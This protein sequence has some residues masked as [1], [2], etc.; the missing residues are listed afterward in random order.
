MEEKREEERRG[1]ERIGEEAGE[2]LTGEKGLQKEDILVSIGTIASLL[3]RS[4][5][6]SSKHEGRVAFENTRAARGLVWDSPGWA[7]IKLGKSLE[8]NGLAGMFR[9]PR[10]VREFPLR[11]QQIPDR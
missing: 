2:G 8:V 6:S 9:D 10:V 3:L 11:T 5:P 1:E 7:R 4:L